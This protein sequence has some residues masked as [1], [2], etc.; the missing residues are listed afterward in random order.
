MAEMSL[1]INLHELATPLESC[2]LEA[3]RMETRGNA[4]R[5]GKRKCIKW[6]KK[7]FLHQVC[8]FLGGKFPYAG[9]C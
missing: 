2:I 7:L 9:M 6:V 5:F 4:L 3:E 8:Y 1:E